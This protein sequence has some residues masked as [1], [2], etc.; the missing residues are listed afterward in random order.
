[1][2]EGDTF[3][4]P[5]GATVSWETDTV[6]AAAQ[7]SYTSGSQFYGRRL[8]EGATLEAED[9]NVFPNAQY[10][11]PPPMPPPP[12]P[13]PP[14]PCYCDYTCAMTFDCCPD[15]QFVC[16]QFFRSDSDGSAGEEEEAVSDDRDS[17]KGRCMDVPLLDDGF[18]CHCDAGCLVAGDCCD[19]KVRFCPS[20]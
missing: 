15:F 13:P 9:R 4:T 17:C 1:M 18:D 16:Q 5:A 8:E 10:Y 12:P 3:S 14:P 6:F 7:P 20:S 11:P 2:V 19:D